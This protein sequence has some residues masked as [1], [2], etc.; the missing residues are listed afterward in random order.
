MYED[1]LSE[2]S[3]TF[4]K[5]KDL[6]LEK[7]LRD[8]KYCEWLIK[9]EWFGSQ[10]QYLYNRVINYKP[11]SYFIDESKDYEYKD[12]DEFIL[13]Y[14]YFNLY[15]IEEVKVMLT[16]NEKICYQFYK[17][18]IDT[19]KDNLIRNKTK[20]PT[21]W[22]KKFEKEYELSRDIFRE[23]LDAYE[24]PN[25]P[26]IVEDIKKVSGIEYK[27]AK[28]YIIA[29]ENSLNQEKYWEDILRKKYGENI[30]AQFKYK[31]CIFDF[32]NIKSNTLYECKLNTKDFNEDQH[33]KY[34]LTL[35]RY[36]IVY[37]ISTDC[38]ID[39][40]HSVIYTTDPLKYQVQFIM[41]KN[42]TKFE[43]LI[44]EFEIV[45]LKNLEKAI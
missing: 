21:S 15:P 30:S 28:S 26:Y 41:N 43:S 32:I 8:R 45:R 18:C 44:S 14:K 1:S 23:F 39:M 31:K 9:Q 4:G 33:N 25:I 6:T 40:E 12:V 35:G 36:N 22:L 20:A 42:P 38:I 2:N 11:Q 27:G 7:M 10:Y 34:K 17:K 16:E 3:I 13:N 29:K 37:L 19:L 5:Y 24:L